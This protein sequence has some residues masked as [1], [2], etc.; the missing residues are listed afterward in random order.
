MQL[1]RTLF[2]IGKSIPLKKERER[3]RKKKAFKFIYFFR[4]WNLLFDCLLSVHIIHS[5]LLGTK[6]WNEKP[7]IFP[8]KKKC[9]PSPPQREERKKIVLLLTNLELPKTPP[10]GLFS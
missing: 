8:V 3:E 9:P 2:S 4:T 10:Q 1:K 6:E 5:I 7:T